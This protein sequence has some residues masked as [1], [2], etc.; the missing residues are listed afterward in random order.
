M[1]PFWIDEEYDREHSDDGV[2]RYAAYV[3]DRMAEFAE[4]WDGTW[5]DGTVPFAR[6]AW[7]VATTPVMAPGYV[8]MHP[9]VLSAQIVRNDWDGGLAADVSLSIPQPPH[10]RW[11]RSDN[12]RGL[13]RDWPTER[14]LDGRTTFYEPTGQEVSSSHYL[15]GSARLC[16]PMADDLLP[17]TLR[18]SH[19]LPEVVVNAAQTAVRVLVRQLNEI[20]GPVLKQIEEG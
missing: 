2:S 4:S 17:T 6:T 8:R 1:D 9:R 3:R 5:D 14:Q 15:L 16:F 10:L 18:T 7:Y 19:H 12:D 13:W 20:V 11:M